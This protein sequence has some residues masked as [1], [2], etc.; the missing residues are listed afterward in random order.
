[1]AIPAYVTNK[2]LAFPAEERRVLTEIFEYLM[3]N[4]R[5]GDPHGTKAANFRAYFVEGTTSST[6]SDEFSILHG[7]ERTPYLALPVLPLGSTGEAI[8][9]LTVSR[10]ADVQRVYLRSPTTSAAICLLL[11]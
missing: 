8:V 7:M 5:F 1:M 11:E 9:P 10:A 2:L 3:P 4:L 6:A